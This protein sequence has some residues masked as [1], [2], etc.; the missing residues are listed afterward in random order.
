MAGATAAMA[1]GS[2]LCVRVHAALLSHLQ[3]RKRDMAAASTCALCATL[4]WRLAPTHDMP[5]QGKRTP[6]SAYLGL[7]SPRRPAH[8]PPMPPF[9]CGSG[10]AAG[11]QRRARS[12]SSTPCSRAR[13][14]TGRSGT[15]PAP[16]TNSPSHQA[17]PT[18]TAHAQSI[19]VSA[20]SPP[21]TDRKPPST[22][23]P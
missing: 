10:A 9:P 17:L 6:H 22:S 2:P 18:R 12:A 16:P 4:S 14:P 8:C 7:S 3:L 5:P 13:T 23:P 21:S 1:R 15:L 20:T 11:V 19:A